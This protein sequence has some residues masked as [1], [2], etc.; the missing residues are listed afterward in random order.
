[1]AAAGAIER[2]PWDSAALGRDAYELS[3]AALE[4]LRQARAP[5]HYTVKVDPLADKRA[6]HEH[7]FYYC[8]TLIE[9]Y[10]AAREFEPQLWSIQQPWFEERI[11]ALR[12][13]ISS[14]P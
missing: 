2:V 5:G 11:A 12:A 9:P 10:C 7:G 4:V 8:D 6:L 3:S 1:M 14:K 13:R